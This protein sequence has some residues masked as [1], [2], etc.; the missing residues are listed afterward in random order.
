MTEHT[1]IIGFDVVEPWP[2]LIETF[3]AFGLK[4]IDFIDHENVYHIVFEGTYDRLK[5]WY[6]EFYAT[7]ES[8]EDYFDSY[9]QYSFKSLYPK[10]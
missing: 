6:N 8:F 4:I 9:T 7:G 1:Y 3:S 2:L 10:K 5:K